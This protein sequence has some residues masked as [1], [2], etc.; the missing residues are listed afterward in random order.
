M[1][2]EKSAKKVVVS[3][4]IGVQVFPREDAQNLNK[5]VFFSEDKENIYDIQMTTFVRDEAT[6]AQG[7]QIF[8]TILSNFT[9]R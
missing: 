4:Q 2:L 7:Q 3:G 9:I 1:N 8:N 6:I 5:V